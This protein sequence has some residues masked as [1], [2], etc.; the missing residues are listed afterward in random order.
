MAR[1]KKP[2][3]PPLH[4]PR[5]SLGPEP[6]EELDLH[7]MAVDEALAAVDQLLLRHKGRSGVIL[8][9]IHGHSNRGLD[10]I[11]TRLHQALG[12]VWKRKVARYRLDF[13]NHGATLVETSGV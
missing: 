3:A 8:R 1:N 5:A 6:D 9:L 12:T 2:K 11:R 7:G 13:H 4:Q 10:S